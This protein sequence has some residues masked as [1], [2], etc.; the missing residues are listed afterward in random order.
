MAEIYRAK[1]T[2]AAGV[3]KSVVVKKILPHYAGN[4]SFVSMFI[5]EAKIAVGLSHGNIAQIFDFGE[6]DG[7][8][9][10]AMEFVDGQPLSRV[11]R[12]A[13][14]MQIPVL[15]TP[16]AVYIAMEVCKGL[17]YAHSRLDEKGRP[18]NIIHRDVSPQNIIVSYEGQVKIVDFG[19]AKA[20]NASGAETEAGAVKGK[21]VYFSPEQAKGKDVDSRADVFALGTC[22]FEMLCGRLPFDGNMI[23][24]LRK[25]IE[26]DYP[27]PRSIN[28]DISPGLERIM[29]T[30]MAGSREERY[31]SAQAFQEAL[32]TY[33]Y[34]NAPAFSAPQLSHF[35]GYLYERA[36]V[37]EGR[38]IQLPKDFLEQAPL[39]K[40]KAQKPRPSEARPTVEEP[41]PPSRRPRADRD[42]APSLIH[43]VP[44]RWLY[45]AA[46]LLAALLAALVVLA[47]GHFGSFSIQLTSTPQG[48]NV[49]VDDQPAPRPTP[50]LISNLSAHRPH[51]IRIAA[52]GME[53]WTREVPPL[54]GGTLFVNA[55]LTPLPGSPQPPPPAPAP[56]VPTPRVPDAPT[57][58]A[59]RVSWPLSGPVE[60]SARRAAYAIPRT[61]A[62]RLP[63]DPAKTYRVW[64]EGK[65]SLGDAMG[66]LWV[67]EAYFFVEGPPELSAGDS[68]GLLTAKGRTVRHASQLYAFLI[69]GNSSDNS[70]SLRI[71]IQERG[72]KAGPQT[73]ILNAK[74]NAIDPA[75][76]ERFYVD[77][78]DPSRRYQVTL[79]QGTP[80]ARLKEGK[81]GGVNRVACA[82]NAGWLQLSK[83]TSDAAFRIFDVGAV[84]E[85]TGASHLEFFFPDASRDDNEGS[86]WLEL[87][88]QAH[89]DPME[90][91]KHLLQKNG[92]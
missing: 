68:F 66:A 34:A 18:L 61:H 26:S 16:F 43:R 13:K 15:P 35:M 36:L 30:A 88:E 56:V 91:L 75:A 17:A 2:G 83:K 63:L 79:K 25:I 85:V 51:R 9:F 64:T 84:Y 41:G 4:R 38:P 82:Q 53:T 87:V 92:G 1:F 42:E 52:V 11:M 23:E 6:I 73:L 32:A 24:V 72:D 81:S 55:T 80:A 27:A 65:L 45:A 86:L 5:N 7:E 19:I 31:P 50:V 60:I 74:E 77:G 21:Y 69:D 44:T 62:A 78:L 58:T 33:L 46:P 89:S 71:R 40:K 57:G 10:L 54:R 47:I 90:N 48:A 8:Y 70:G 28:P 3:T 22:L 39:W 14:E 12:R 49:T 67:D 29:K 37:S 59:E 76:D 20:R